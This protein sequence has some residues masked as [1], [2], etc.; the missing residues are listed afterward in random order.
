MSTDAYVYIQQPGGVQLYWGTLPLVL[1]QRTDPQAS[2][3]A[4]AQALATL[5]PEGFA[6]PREPASVWMRLLH[7]V[8]ANLHEL[9]AWLE[10]ATTEWLPHATHTRLAEW[11]AALGLPDPCFGPLQTTAAR[12]AA[13]L[14]LLRGNPGHYADSS[15][16]APA[17]I[18][19]RAAA[20]GFAATVTYNWPMRV[21]DAVGSP[22]GGPAGVLHVQVV[23]TE[24][25]F[26]MGDPVGNRL[27]EPA[28]G[29]NEL[30]CALQ[31]LVPA[32][33]QI[34]VTV[35]A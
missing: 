22:V 21:G 17:A 10:Q 2:V 14:T 30:G 16:A 24:T 1:R 26:R 19:A 27:G 18:Q 29:V 15:P 7:G 13:V 5:L 34:N 25:L 33:F 12:Q 6:W 28:P 9:H 8:A 32:R 31:R 23:G 4:V 35:V 11:E 20:M 3:K